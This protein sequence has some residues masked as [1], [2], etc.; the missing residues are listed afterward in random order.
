MSSSG[1]LKVVQNLPQILF[2]L[3]ENFSPWFTEF[4]IRDQQGALTF[5]FPAGANAMENAKKFN[6][7]LQNL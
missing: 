7:K 2:K 6:A 3:V 5:F 1:F 4:I